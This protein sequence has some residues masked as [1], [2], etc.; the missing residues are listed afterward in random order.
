MSVV[1]V[2]KAKV[3]KVTRTKNNKNN[4]ITL[5]K[6]RVLQGMKFRT[7][8]IKSLKEIYKDSYCEKA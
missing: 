1:K 7:L 5:K 8:L 3:K 6:I 2:G 4:K